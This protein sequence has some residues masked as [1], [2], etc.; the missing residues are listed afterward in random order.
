MIA[1]GR[2]MIGFLL[3]AVMMFSLVALMPMEALPAQAVGP[4]ADFTADPTTGTA[5]LTVQFTD[6]S[7]D[8][9]TSWAWDFDNDGEVDSNEQNPSHTYNTA[10]SYSVKLTVANPDGWSYYLQGD[11]IHVSQ[12][13]G[14]S[15]AFTADPATGTAPLTVQ[16]TDQST[17]YITAWAWDFDND[18]EVDSNEQNPSHSY[19]TAGRYTVSLTVTGPGGPNTE[20]EVDYIA[21]SAAPGGLSGA[22]IAGIGI[23]VCA[24]AGLIA[25]FVIRR[26]RAAGK[27]A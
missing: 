17:G 26:R 1:G 11:Y 4:S 12:A 24:A 8:D 20:V 14:P 27:R 15:A 23:G 18:G 21:V 22:A 16:F 6:Q 9:P 5:P 7:W 13:V 25:Y 3:A 10:G 19:N 2:K